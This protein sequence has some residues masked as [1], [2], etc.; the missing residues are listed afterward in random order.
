MYWWNNALSEAFNDSFSQLNIG[1]HMLLHKINPHIQVYNNS[2]T[3]FTHKHKLC[4][5]LSFYFVIRW[6]I[7]YILFFFNL[8]NYLNSSRHI[9]PILI[10]LFLHGTWMK[11]LLPKSKVIFMGFT[12]EVVLIVE[13]SFPEIKMG[14]FQYLMMFRIGFLYTLAILWNFSLH[15]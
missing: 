5:W 11:F 3:E 8:F 7:S 14:I 4:L 12:V 1:S 2:N 9:I 10:L 6:E 13:D 15:I